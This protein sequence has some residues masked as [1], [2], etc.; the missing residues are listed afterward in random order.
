MM[1]K[2][3]HKMELKTSIKKELIKKKKRNNFMTK[4]KRK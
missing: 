3:S 4:Y 2:L 1:E